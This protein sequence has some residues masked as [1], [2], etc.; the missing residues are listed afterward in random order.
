ML[1]TIVNSLAIIFGAF[2]GLFIKGGLKPRYR[3]ILMSVLGL[4]VVFI[5]ISTALEGMLSDEAKPVLYIVSLVIGSLIGESLKMEDRLE[6]F[7]NLIES[8]TKS[9]GGNISQG[10]VTGS[11][12]F[13]VGTM[14]VIGSIESGVQGVHTTLFTKAVIDG[15]MA[16][17]FASTLGV[18]V[19]LSAVSVF[20]YQ[21]LLT[22][23]ASLIQ[24]YLTNEMLV[25]ISIVGGI[26]ITAIGVNTLEIKKFK[27][28]NML[29]AIAVP[30]IYY[31]PPV[32]RFMQTIYS[33]IN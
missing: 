16:L 33:F 26:M 19:M 3:E 14:A 32:I 29:P 5:G 12:T 8:A 13:C 24:P 17:V 31:I 18:G 21:G 25:E 11:L 20:I 22:V 30:V 23:F 4:S 1:G 9:K 6:S 2:V 28:G 27:V 10:F 15:V 7:G